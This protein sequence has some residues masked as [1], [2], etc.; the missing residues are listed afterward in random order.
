MYQRNEFRARARQP[1]A[2][3]SVLSSAISFSPYK[4]TVWPET[5]LV[6]KV[7]RPPNCYFHQLKFHDGNHC[8]HRMRGKNTSINHIDK[9]VLSSGVIIAIGS[10]SLG[11][12]GN[13]AK[14]PR[15][16]TLCSDCRGVD[17]R[18]RLNIV[19]LQID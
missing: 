18:V 2:L 11:L 12:V 10:T 1:A 4:L 19:N 3:W 9:G 7:A 16:T 5:K 6:P 14:S 13:T 17:P 8:A 15:S